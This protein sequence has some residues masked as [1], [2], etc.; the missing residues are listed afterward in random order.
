[1]NRC[2]GMNYM[3]SRFAVDVKFSIYIHI[4]I[5]RF[6]VDIHGYIH[7]HRRLSCVHIATIF[8]RNT[9]VPERPFLPC[10]SFVKLL[11]I[12]K[13]KKIKHICIE[14]WLPPPRRLCFCQTL[15]V[16]LFVCLRVSKITQKVID[17]FFWN[18]L[19]MSGIAKTTSD[20]ILGV[21]RKESWILDHFE[22]FVTI[23]FNGA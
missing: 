20:S 12:N 10:S 3:I 21:I 8:S 23:A 5:H 16:C 15:F 18:F 4:H 1:M 2:W 7:I 11:K 14:M 6:S 22:I 19:G 13:S 9:A 17:G